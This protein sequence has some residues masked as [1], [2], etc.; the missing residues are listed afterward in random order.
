MGLECTPLSGEPKR[1]QFARHSLQC[2][3]I[4]WPCH[5]D[6]TKLIEFGGRPR[7]FG[8]LLSFPLRYCRVFLKKIRARLTVNENGSAAPYLLGWFIGI[9]VPLLLLIAMLRGCS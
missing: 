4:L 9:P 6:V 8:K 5:F 2:S 7:S 1:N 3:R